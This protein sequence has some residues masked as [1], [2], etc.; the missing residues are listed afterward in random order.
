MRTFPVKET[1]L[2]D[3]KLN[4]IIY[5]FYQTHSYLTKER[6]RYCIKSE[7]SP[8]RIINYFNEQEKDCPVSERTIRNMVKLFTSCGVLTEGELDKKKVYY[9]HD[10]QPGEYVYLKT[11]TLRFLV[12]TS[13]SNVIKVYAFLKAKQKQ[14]IDLKYTEPYRF[15]KKKILEI[16]GYCGTNND[17]AHLAMVGDILDTLR[18]NGLV[19]WHQERILTTNGNATQ[20]YVLD[21][22]NEDYIHSTC[23]GLN[24]KVKTYIAV[25][26]SQELDRFVF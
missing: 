25:P 13:T 24:Q 21:E 5:G 20:Y 9:L 4:D 11:D 23:T 22:V 1:F 16:L 15:S 7:T 6:K 17:S 8:A 12:N 10:L 2:G 18:N 14:H 26:I 3:K 19:Q